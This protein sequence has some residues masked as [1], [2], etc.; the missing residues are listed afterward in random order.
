MQETMARI[1]ESQR[2]ATREIR[3]LYRQ[4]ARSEPVFRRLQ[5][6]AEVLERELHDYREDY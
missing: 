6:N 5:Q 1:N 2:E 4:L 3:N